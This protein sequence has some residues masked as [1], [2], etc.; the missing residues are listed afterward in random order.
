MDKLKYKSLLDLINLALGNRSWNQYAMAAGV[1]SG[2]LTRIKN[3]NF[4]NPPKPEFL[5]KLSKKAHNG[6]TYESLM[7]AAG[8]TEAFS[9]ADREKHEQ[10]LLDEL[11]EYPR[12]LKIIS[13]K[14]G[15][16]NDF[17]EEQ[18]ALL[19]KMARKKD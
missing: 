5:L 3:G 1:D 15:V 13:D 12:A 7:A 9:Y 11:K 18:L 4:K 2:H 14:I 10:K 6:V 16:P 19:E 8:Y 17:L